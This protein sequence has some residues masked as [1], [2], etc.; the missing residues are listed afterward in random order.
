MIEI[1]NEQEKAQFTTP[2]P[3]RLIKNLIILGSHKDDI[4]LDS[5][6]GSGT[7]GHA[8]LQLNKEDGGNR[9]FILIEMEADIAR[10]IT[11]ERI[12]RVSEGYKIAKENG[13]IEVVEGLGGG[14]KYCRFADPLFDRM[15]NISESVNL[16]N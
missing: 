14:F 1:F 5:F 10:N 2:K 8:V 9:K 4:I 13:D 6:A 11:A 15:G 16:Q 12:K 3:L 7:T